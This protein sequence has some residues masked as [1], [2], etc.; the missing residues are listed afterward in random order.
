VVSEEG[1][2]SPEAEREARRREEVS[3]DVDDFDGRDLRVNES[4]DGGEGGGNGEGHEVGGGGGESKGG[5]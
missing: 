1:V 3:V 5:A 2:D 4:L